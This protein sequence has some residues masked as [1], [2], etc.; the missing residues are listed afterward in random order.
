M[1]LEIKDHSISV[2]QVNENGVISFKNPW[3]YP[4]PENFPTNDFDIR[5]AIAVAPFWSDNDIRKDG[6]VRYAIYNRATDDNPAGRA[7]LDV[8]NANIQSQ[9][10]GE[11][12][13]EG[14][15]MLIAHW[16]GVH[17]SPHGGD[18]HGG[19]SEEEL[20]RVSICRKESLNE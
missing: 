12:L 3:M 16:D 19:I 7:L 11:V 10:G 5:N 4:Y 8:V 18:D 13:F 17:P 20:N 6:T 9:Q 2:F 14:L 15:W 1:F